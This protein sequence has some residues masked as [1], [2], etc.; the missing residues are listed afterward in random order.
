LSDLG[1]LKE[2]EVSLRK[3]IE[4]KP[5]FAAAAWNLYGLSNSIEEAEERINQCLKM[6]ENYLEAKLTLS[7]LKLH[8]GDQSLFDNLIKS[9]HKD[10][11]T[12]R[13][14]KWVSTLPEVT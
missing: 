11:P 9:I 1:K 2:A 13:S 7:A 8:Q 6:D 4:I 3:A 10:H 12:T 5:N 14:I